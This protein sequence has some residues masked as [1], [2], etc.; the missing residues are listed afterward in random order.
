MHFKPDVMVIYDRG[1]TSTAGSFKRTRFNTSTQAVVNGK[2]AV[3]TTATGQVVALDALLPLNTTL[4]AAPIENLG[5][6]I[7]MMDPMGFNISSEDL[8]APANVRFLNVIHGADNILGKLPVTLLTSSDGISFDG[9]L[10]GQQAVMFKRDVTTSF[11]GM[12]FT[13][14]VGTTG[15]V[16][17]LAPY[18]SYTVSYQTNGGNVLVTVTSGG[19]SK[20]DSG[21]IIA[22]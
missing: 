9:A 7:G 20:A 22:F 10:V 13:V 21:G 19:S 15:Y 11:T 16:T 2:T 5:Y 18:A 12:S 8:S 4:T 1:A 3:A 17:G 14:P 6:E